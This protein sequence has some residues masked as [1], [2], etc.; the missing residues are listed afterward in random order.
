MNKKAKR[1]RDAGTP[2][3]REEIG[4][5]IRFVREKKGMSQGKLADRLGVNR[6]TLTYWENG[7]RDIKTTDI[8]RLAD[9]LGVTCDYI[10]NGSSEK[11]TIF[12][13]KLCELIK[14]RKTT[15]KDVANHL[16]FSRQ[17]VSQYCNENTQPNVDAILKIA[18]Y[19]NVSCDYLLRGISSENLSISEETGLSEDAIMVLRQYRNE[20]SGYINAINSLITNKEFMR[21]LKG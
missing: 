10:L 8:V 6:V 14:E 20:D 16:G 4:E 12:A 7:T 11:E 9:A 1:N 17:A 21:L 15:I 3:A 5:R 2:Y 19:F 13:T 18:E